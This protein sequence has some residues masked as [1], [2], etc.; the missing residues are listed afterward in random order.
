[1]AVGLAPHFAAENRNVIVECRSCAGAGPVGSAI[2][3]FVG[4]VQIVIANARLDFEPARVIFIAVQERAIGAGNGDGFAIRERVTEKIGAGFGFAERG[5]RTIELGLHGNED[6]GRRLGRRS[7]GATQTDGAGSESGDGG[8]NLRCSFRCKHRC[9]HIVLCRINKFKLTLRF[10]QM[11]DGGDG[12]GIP[13]WW[14]ELLVKIDASERRP[15][16]VNL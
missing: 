10:S 2:A 7:R 1:M 3:E 16:W 4:A 15:K 14:I 11:S 9:T 6:G 5:Y 8:E 12:E 13:G